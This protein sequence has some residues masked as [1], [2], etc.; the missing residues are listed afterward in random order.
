[1]RLAGLNV[2]NLLWSTYPGFTT[3]RPAAC[4]H[5]AVWIELDL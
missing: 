4:D 3:S 2:A 5:A 1:M